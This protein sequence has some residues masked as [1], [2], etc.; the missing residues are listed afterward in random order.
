M[1]FGRKCRRKFGVKKLLVL[2][3]LCCLAMYIGSV[4]YRSKGHR[5]VWTVTGSTNI[6]AG[7]CGVHCGYGQI[8]FYVKT[9]VETKQGPVICYH[10]QIVVS[11]KMKNFDR[12]INAVI[13]N[14]RTLEVEFVKTYDTYVDDYEF[15][16]DMKTK[17]KEGFIAIL[18]S[19]DEI[20]EN[21]SEEGHRWVKMF[22]SELI[23]QVSFRDSFMLIGQKGLKQGYAIEFF[24]S[25]GESLFGSAIEKQGCFTTPLGPVLPME[26][27]MYQLVSNKNVKLGKPMEHCGL[28]TACAAKQFPVMISTGSESTKLPEICVSGYMVM[29]GELNNAGRGMNV[30]IVDP[31]TGK[32]KSVSRFDTYEKDSLNMELYLD[33]MKPGDIVIAVAH[34]DASRKL[35]FHTRE[36]LNQLGSGMAQNIKFRDVWFFVGQKGIDGFTNMEKISYAGMDAEWPTP[37]IEAFCVPD[38]IVGSQV[39]PDPPA[40]RNDIRR[41]FCK[42]YDGY[43]EF[44]DPSHVDEPFL[45]PADLTDEKLKENPVYS[46]P[47]LIIPGL[48]HNALVRTLETTVMQQGVKLENVLVTFDEKFPEQGELAGLFGFQNVSLDGSVQYSDQVIKALEKTA[49]IFPKARYLIVI[50]EELVLSPD[51]LYFLAQCTPTLDKDPSLLGV[52]AFNFHGFEE[53]SSNKSLVYRVEDFPGL[54]FMIKMSVYKERMKGSLK[55]CCSDR[56]WYGWSLPVYNQSHAGYMLLPDVSRVYRQPF[57]GFNVDED[58]LV[59]LFNKPRETNLDRNPKLL[60]MEKLEQSKYDSVIKQYILS[61]LHINHGNIRNCALNGSPLKLPESKRNFKLFYKQTTGTDFTVLQKFSKCFHIVVTAKH[62]P[63]HLYKGLLRFTYVGNN[64]MLIGSKSEFA[65]LKPNQTQ[66][67]DMK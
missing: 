66:F 44:C 6:S 14:D 45:K 27:V 39:I 12:G 54:A 9:G 36:K 55:S 53:L 38:K 7:H 56:A 51:F 46:S 13:I 58:Y 52:S 63:K 5:E 20:S 28:K 22:G 49:S 31:Q 16:R 23:D 67:F 4:V 50:E 29:D 30:V 25:K 40:N 37:I 24:Q 26:E 60:G 33:S 21:L 2:T 59:S 43:G 57:E 42:K 47:I 62:P 41:E 18:A 19:Y 1:T 34:D 35:N 48:N 3:V 10:N 61:A 17:V 8:G 15:L 65:A 32:P 11:D 64:I